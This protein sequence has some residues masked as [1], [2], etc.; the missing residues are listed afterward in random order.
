[1]A[2]GTA[3]ER[4]GRGMGTA[5][6]VW[7]SL[8]KWC[9]PRPESMLFLA[10]FFLRTC[11]SDSPAHF[12]RDIAKCITWTYLINISVWTEVIPHARWHTRRRF[13]HLIPLNC[14]DSTLILERP[15]RGCPFCR[16]YWDR[17]KTKMTE[18]GGHSSAWDLQC[19]TD[20]ITST[21][22]FFFTLS[23]TSECKWQEIKPAFSS[24]NCTQSA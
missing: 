10:P 15:Q 18:N 8:N 12:I 1:M 16:Q 5:S 13:L 14:T 21:P 19:N 17:C 7:I 2:R 6:Y 3:R 24:F 9:K 4:H 11:L 20:L 23:E 22:D